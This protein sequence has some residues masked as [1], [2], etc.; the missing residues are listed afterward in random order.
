MEKFRGEFDAEVYR[1]AE[2]LFRN[3]NID[4]VYIATPHQCHAEH[5]IMAATYGKHAIVE[6]PMAL[7]LADCDNMIAAV[8]RA[9]IRLVVGH[10]DSFD[11]P[12]LKIR[13]I[14]RG[15][16]FGAFKM[17]H[18]WRFTNFLYRP[19]RPEEL[20]TSLGGGILFNQVPHQIDMIRWIG[21]GEDAQRALD[22]R[23]LRLSAPNRRRPTQ[24]LGIRR[25]RRRD[26]RLQRLRS[27]RQRRIDRL[28]RRRQ[29]AQ[30]TRSTGRSPA[31][32]KRS[33]KFRG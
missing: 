1:N 27:L 33:K 5:V 8:D 7:T 11:P 4:A 22:D 9:G 3:Q 23:S 26:P 21:G 31:H 28:D 13:E 30:A 20:D 6:K 29:Q 10:T 24:L 32:S 18:T 2:E 25:R 14:V 12:I 17:M 19:R 15:G 16:E